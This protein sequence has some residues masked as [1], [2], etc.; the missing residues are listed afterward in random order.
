MPQTQKWPTLDLEV[1]EIS[2]L[3]NMEVGFLLIVSPSMPLKEAVF[4]GGHCTPLN[5]R[6]KLVAFGDFGILLAEGFTGSIRLLYVGS[7]WS[8]AAT[9]AC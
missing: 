1:Q 2:K 5:A 6:L 7:G 4:A 8:D 3:A 9:E